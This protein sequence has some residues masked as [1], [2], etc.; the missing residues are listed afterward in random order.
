M[1]RAALIDAA[2]LRR[3][4]AGHLRRRIERLLDGDE[5][6]TRL[7]CCNS[8]CFLCTDELLKIVA[9]VEELMKAK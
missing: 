7:R 9:E 2:L 1:D 8:G 4:Y 5:D 6:R 3:N